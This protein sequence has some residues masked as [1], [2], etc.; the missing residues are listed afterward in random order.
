MEQVWHGY[1]P[2]LP[3]R[4][5][6]SKPVG[7]AEFDGSSW[8][9]LMETVKSSLAAVTHPVPWQPISL[10]GLDIAWVGM[11]VPD[12]DTNGRPWVWEVV[13]PSQFSDTPI[14]H[15]DPMVLPVAQDTVI[16]NV[17]HPD[18]SGP[19]VRMQV[20]VRE[21]PDVIE[22][23]ADALPG[24][25]WEFSVETGWTARCLEAAAQEWIDREVGFGPR[26]DSNEPTIES[27]ER[28]QISPSIS[29]ESSAFDRLLSLAPHDA[30]VVSSALCN[31]HEAL[32]P[33]R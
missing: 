3:T 8:R 27:T 31:I 14:L 24:H 25:P 32:D 18:H 30:A 22:V 4:L 17:N 33:Y 26:L 6:L 10:K 16:V 20:P 9:S 29:I 23:G 15:D 2:H 21:A 5:A 11:R 19:I 13:T 28:Y 1:P 12:I 7:L